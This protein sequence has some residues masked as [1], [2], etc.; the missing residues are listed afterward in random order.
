MLGKNK[1]NASEE[2][3]DKQATS[4]KHIISKA[5]RKFAGK[6][7]SKSLTGSCILEKKSQSG[8]AQRDTFTYIWLTFIDL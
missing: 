3:N 2:Q 7:R 4:Y 8:T 5:K 6:D 1:R